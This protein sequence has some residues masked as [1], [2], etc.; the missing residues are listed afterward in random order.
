[1]MARV[2]AAAP[3]HASME[4]TTAERRA[5]VRAF[6]MALTPEDRMRIGS[7]MSLAARELVTAVV[8]ADL[9][10]DATEADVRRA[11]FL[12]FYGR[13]L[14]RE[15]CI[16]ICAAM[17]RRRRAREA[18]GV[19]SSDPR[20]TANVASGSGEDAAATPRVRF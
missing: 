15:R 5:R 2:P 10:R 14:G 8:R 11:V 7:R 18:V 20:A 4:D 13:E 19:T 1:M 6:F 3:K 12:Q 16:E 17:E 9:G